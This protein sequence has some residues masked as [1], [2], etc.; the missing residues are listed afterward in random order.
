MFP[1]FLYAPASAVSVINRKYK[2]IPDRRKKMDE[3]IYFIMKKIDFE[4]SK[5]WKFSQ[6]L[7][8]NGVSIG[9]LRAW[10]TETHFRGETDLAEGDLPPSPANVSF[11]IPLL[12]HVFL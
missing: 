4:N 1:F 11:S 8:F 3:K 5:I 7:D 12:K 10:E 6:N 2:K 9:F